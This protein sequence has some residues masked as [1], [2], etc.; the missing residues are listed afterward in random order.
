MIGLFVALLIIAI[1][2][3][4]IGG[5]G[6]LAFGLQILFWIIIVAI[7]IFIIAAVVKFVVR[8]T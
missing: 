4:L 8:R 5:V 1:I 3:L 2:L 6:F 7:I